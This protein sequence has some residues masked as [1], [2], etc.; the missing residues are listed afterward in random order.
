MFLTKTTAEIFEQLIEVNTK[1]N[2]KVFLN[3]CVRGFTDIIACISITVPVAVSWRQFFCMCLTFN[4][5]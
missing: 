5:N 3:S 2:T 4:Y 1:V